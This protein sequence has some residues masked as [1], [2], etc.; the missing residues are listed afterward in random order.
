M[1]RL[2]IYFIKIYYKILCHCTKNLLVG[3]DNISTLYFHTLQ[4]YRLKTPPDQPQRVDLSYGTGF[5]DESDDSSK[6]SSGGA[7]RPVGKAFQH[8]ALKVG[9]DV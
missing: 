4:V 8:Q 1:A 6:L 7:G 5:V 2:C 3:F 9:H